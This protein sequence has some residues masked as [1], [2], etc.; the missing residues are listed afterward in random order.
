MSGARESR[1]GEGRRVLV[2]DDHP[3]FRA[4]IVAAWRRWRDQD[5][6]SEAD[7]LR[8]GVRN[9][10]AAKPDVALIDLKL[11]DGCGLELCRRL[12]AASCPLVV[13]LT[14]YDGV[15][16]VEASRRV[17]ARGFFSK[18]LPAADLFL[19]IDRLLHHATA[20]SFPNVSSLPLLTSRETEV[21]H[22]LLQGQSN[23]EIAGNLNVGIETV[24]THVS[25]V[26]SRLGARDRFEATEIARGFGFDIAI[27]HLRDA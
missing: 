18:E 25:S 13:L 3:L 7:S 17:G 15:A 14:T 4:G 27:P 9:A 11:P 1:G 21:L 19:E 5:R 8:T 23:P 24:K 26:L 10:E 22:W 12:V 2:V 16:I 20:T 6:V